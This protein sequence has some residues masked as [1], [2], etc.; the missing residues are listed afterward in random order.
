MFVRIDI[1]EILNT[2]FLQHVQ[3]CMSRPGNINVFL[4]N[5][6]RFLLRHVELNLRFIVVTIDE[7]TLDRPEVGTGFYV[8]C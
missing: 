4:W 8:I 5:R 3:I 7:V 1:P 6:K 2:F